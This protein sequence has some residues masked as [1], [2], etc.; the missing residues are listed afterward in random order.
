[1]PPRSALV[2]GDVLNRCVAVIKHIPAGLLTDI[3]GTISPIA[4]VPGDAR[5]DA[6][7]QAALDRLN[8][9]LSLVGVVTGR[10]VTVARGMVGLPDLLY[11]GNHGLEREYR[12]EAWTHPGADAESDTMA[13]ALREIANGAQKH[14]VADGVVIED[15]RLSGSIHYRLAP[16]PDAARSVL[17]PLTMDVAQHS[18]L[19]VTSGLQVIELRPSAVVNKGTA[20]VDLV[21]RHRLRGV[22]FFG[23]DLTDVDGFKAISVLRESGTIDALLIGVV[24][25]E[26]HPSVLSHADVV[27]S[28]VAG[29]AALLGALANT[30]AP[31]PT[32]DVLDGGVPTP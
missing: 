20:I 9:H 23:D 4:A 27:V 2:D 8:H 32:A 7:A 25:P 28:G 18:G 11:I 14:G 1:M 6:V 16:D 13:A 30:L 26:T 3:D 17:L 10:A 19:V 12:G 31:E 15:K 29:C 24:S 5:V 22:L 21:A